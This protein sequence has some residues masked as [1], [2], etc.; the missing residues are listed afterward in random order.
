MH[1]VGRLRRAAGGQTLST[2]PSTSPPTAGRRC[3]SCR[4]ARTTWRVA[5][6]GG[7][8]YAFVASWSRTE[9]PTTGPTPSTGGHGGRCAGC[10]R[11]A[12]RSPAWGSAKPQSTSSAAR[13]ARTTAARSTGTSSTTRRPTP[14]AAASPC[15]SA[16]TIPGSSPPNGR[17]HIIGGRVDSFH[18]NSNLHHA[19]DPATDAAW[20]FLAPIPTARSGM[21]RCCS[22]AAYT[23]WAARAR[24]ALYGQ[25][26]SYDIAANRWESH[27]PDAD[28][29][30]TAW[31]R[32]SSAA[33]SLW[34]ARTANGR[35]RE[36]RHQ[37]S[38]LAKAD[39]APPQHRPLV[40]R[41]PG[42]YA[43]A[44]TSGAPAP[45][46]ERWQSGSIAPHS[47]CGVPQGTGGSNPPSSAIH[48][49]TKPAE[50]AAKL[51]RPPAHL[52]KSLNPF[53][54]PRL[55]S[56]SSARPAALRGE[57]GAAAG[58]GAAVA[59]A[60]IVRKR[61]WGIHASAAGR[62][63]DGAGSPSAA[64]PDGRRR[65]RPSRADPPRPWPQS[66]TANTALTVK[67][68]SLL[69]VGSRGSAAGACGSVM[70]KPCRLRRNAP[71]Q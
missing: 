44:Q 31:A 64:V 53:T 63:R 39:G 66:P 34:R 7:L 19:Y 52:P 26:E 65:R 61:R 60:R 16:A 29:A 41:S 58:D 43:H 33:R 17:I 46:R 1:L 14:T 3:R 49:R 32:S 9:R 27:A 28:A 57:P 40:F 18:T 24:T 62:W 36:E 50:A 11:P 8:L 59:V 20:T 22:R 48:L 13:S 4:G 45:R 6:H 51:Q 70:E 47:K 35:R 15:R 71:E 30:A 23:A 42:S 68:P 56:P 12:A 25:N 69:N 21:D 5:A 38:L 54:N 2:T 67:V 37:R 10:P 55:I